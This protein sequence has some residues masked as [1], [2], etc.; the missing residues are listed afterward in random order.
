MYPGLR[1]RIGGQD[2]IERVVAVA[3][4]GLHMNVGARQLPEADEH[5][6]VPAPAV[7]ARFRGSPLFWPPGEGAG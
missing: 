5:D 6:V 3:Q 2:A 1:L 4:Q 7:R